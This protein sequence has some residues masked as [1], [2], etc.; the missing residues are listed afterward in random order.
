MGVGG[1]HLSLQ[2]VHPWAL[3]DFGMKKGEDEMMKYKHCV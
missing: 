2:N 3:L 1:D